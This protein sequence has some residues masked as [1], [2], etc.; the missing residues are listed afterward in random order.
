M[1]K[2]KLNRK[3]INP[4]I[5]VFT[6]IQYAENVA[7]QLFE[8]NTEKFVEIKN[9]STKTFG[10]FKDETDQYW[11]NTHGIHDIDRI[12]SICEQSNL[13]SL[14]I[15]DIL[16]VNQ[17]PKFQGFENYWFFSIKS[18]LPATGNQ[19]ESE[20]LSFVLGRNY[21]M[22]FQ[23]K[24]RDYFNHVRKR[25]RDNVGIVR[26][27]GVDYLLY[28]LLE[29]ILDNYFKTIE[30][31]EISL[32]GLGL[33]NLDTD[34][35]PLLL[36]TIE[37]FQQQVH[38]VRKTINPIKEFITKIEREESGFINEK[39]LKYYYELKDLCLT[40]I[41]ECDQLDLRLTGNINLFF[42]LQG[43][44]MNNVMK[45]LTIV[46]TIFIPLTFIAGIYGMNFSHMPELQLEWGYYGV[47][48]VILVI[49]LIMVYYFKRKKWF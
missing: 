40:L 28:L 26:S 30:S 13:H 29:S 47:W 7:I 39:H 36:K 4:N 6:G 25:I 11:L 38:H 22:S 19:I 31:I 46:A 43:N 45:T 16:D 23:E 20:Q 49:F 37:Q 33:L 21:L 14:T 24:E 5:A 2:K 12:V 17:R 3:K 35:S 44:R 42:S 41:D 1:A 32:D 15:Q 8:Y 10:G 34:P 27:R 18:V 9:L 48:I